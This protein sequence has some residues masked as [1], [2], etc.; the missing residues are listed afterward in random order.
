LLPSENRSGDS[1]GFEERQSVKVL[2]E[3]QI[4]EGRLIRPAS[5]AQVLSASDLYP[6]GSP[7]VATEVFETKPRE[8]S[9][10][11]QQ[12]ELLTIADKPFTQLPVSD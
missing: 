2:Q 4:G 3:A 10:V 6:P 7:K 5:E 1:A 11:S 8:F 9:R 12:N